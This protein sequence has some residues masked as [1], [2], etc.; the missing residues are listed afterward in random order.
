M[1]NCLFYALF[2]V[3]FI[4][5]TCGAIDFSG[6]NRTFKGISNGIFE[7]AA[8]TIDSFGNP[9][10]PYFDEEMLETYVSTYF[11]ENLTRYV[12]YYEARIYFFN[13]DANETIC[14]DK[15]CSCVKI[16]LKCDINFLFHYEKGQNFYLIA[17]GL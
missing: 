12:L 3:L 15:K 1:T 2:F 5:F 6:V 7:S 10:T 16:T 4:N 11:K 14:T 8:Y 13:N 17:S 9:T